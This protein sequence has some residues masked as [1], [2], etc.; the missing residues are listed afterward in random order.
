MYSCNFSELAAANPSNVGKA[1][2][3]NCSPTTATP[4]ATEAVTQNSK[5]S[6]TS[7]EEIETIA[8]EIR[9]SRKLV[10]A[11]ISITR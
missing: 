7:I 5:L 11:S 3:S 4:A 2:Q 1:V 6:L 8:W 10:Q 9:V